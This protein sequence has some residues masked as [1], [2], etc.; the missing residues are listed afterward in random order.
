MAQAETAELRQAEDLRAQ[1]A[2]VQLAAVEER[3]Q[4]L[5]ITRETLTEFTG[6]HLSHADMA[7]GDGVVVEEEP[8][9]PARLDPEAE[10]AQLPPLR[11]F[12]Q[13]VVALLA[14]ADEPMRAREIVQAIGKP[15]TRS[16]VEGM[17]SRLQRLVTDGWLCWEADGLYAIAA[18]STATHRP[19]RPIDHPS[20]ITAMPC[21]SRVPPRLRLGGTRARSCFRTG[22]CEQGQ[23]PLSLLVTAGQRGDSPQFRAVLVETLVQLSLPEGRSRHCQRCPPPA[24][25]VCVSP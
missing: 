20:L 1:L 23:R 7:E 18:G 24:E 5:A 21:M 14:T 19:G 16:Q 9:A 11:G 6:D 3:L 4:R 8:P 17:R 15:D 25:G 13:Q 22:A 12:R 10:H 2:A